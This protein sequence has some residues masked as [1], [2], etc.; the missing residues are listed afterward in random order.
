MIVIVVQRLENIFRFLFSKLSVSPAFFAGV[1]IHRN[2]MHL[3][4]RL[5]NKKVT[6]YIPAE[7]TRQQLTFLNFALLCLHE[8]ACVSK[9]LGMEDGSI[10]DNKITASSTHMRSR[11]AWGRLHCSDGS[12]TPNTDSFGEWLQVDFAPEVKLITHIAIQGNGKSWWWVASYYVM[13]GT[14]GVVIEDYKENNQQV[15]SHVIN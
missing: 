14:G 6:S 1:P 4:K 13:Y 7:N 15:V 8:T 12:W 5:N 10:A 11:A 9:P 2:T 3:T